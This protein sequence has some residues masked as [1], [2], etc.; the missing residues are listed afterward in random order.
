MTEGKLYAME[1]E[2]ERILTS[3]ADT[4]EEQDRLQ[5]RAKSIGMELSGVGRTRQPG[6]QTGRRNPRSGPAAAAK[7][8]DEGRM[9]PGRINKNTVGQS[10][11]RNKVQPVVRGG[12][13]KGT[14]ARRQPKRPKVLKKVTLPST[15]RLENLTNILGVKLCM[16]RVLDSA[17]FTR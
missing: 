14:G 7:G 9:V 16:F 10:V 3:K 1:R 5:R 12:A 13:P 17:K 6:E 2:R 8:Q 15:V 11:D 4:P